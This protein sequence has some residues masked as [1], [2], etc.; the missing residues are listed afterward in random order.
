MTSR[1]SIHS[2][3]SSIMETMAKSAFSQVCKLVDQ[4]SA[5]LRSELSR[6]LFANS[7]LTEKVNSLE[8]ELTSA[9]RDTPKK[10]R[11]YCSVGVQT[12]CSRD[13]KHHDGI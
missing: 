5:E 4:D 6:L 8:C 11:S 9:V 10:S 7:A 2:Q 13:E 12:V 3:L 1:V